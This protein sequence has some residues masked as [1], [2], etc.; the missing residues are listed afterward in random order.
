MENRH[1]LCIKCSIL[2]KMYDI[3]NWFERKNMPTF[4]KAVYL[5]SKPFYQTI[6][7]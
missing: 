7:C 3:G 6:L 5:A 4:A 2:S 1:K